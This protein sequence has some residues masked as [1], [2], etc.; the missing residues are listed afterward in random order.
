MKIFH[1][2]IL[3]SIPH[4]A[5]KAQ[6]GFHCSKS[7]FLIDHSITVRCS[8]VQRIPGESGK[9]VKLE[10][11]NVIKRSILKIRNNDH[12]CLPWSLKAAYVYSLR[13]RVSLGPLHEK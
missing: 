13:G 9:R 8:I 1:D 11:E 5:V 3:V 6:L 7:Q 2:R 10:S 12:L 4:K